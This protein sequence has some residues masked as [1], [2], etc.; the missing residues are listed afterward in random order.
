MRLVSYVN[1]DA[2]VELGDDVLNLN[3]AL[4]AH[5]GFS[6]L[7]GR[8]IDIVQSDSALEHLKGAV[9]LIASD[10]EFFKALK[11]MGPEPR[12]RLR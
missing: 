4:K 7:P 6:G 5:P 9:K 2:G 3:A 1:G 11:S 8:V 12:F 10:A